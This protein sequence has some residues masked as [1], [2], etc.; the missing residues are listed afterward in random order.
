MTSAGFVASSNVSEKQ[1]EPKRVFSLFKRKF[2]FQKSVCF[3]LLHLQNLR[4]QPTLNFSQLV[5]NVGFFISNIVVIVVVV[6]AAVGAVD[7]VVVSLVI[8]VVVAVV[9]VVI[10][11]TYVDVVVLNYCGEPR[12]CIYCQ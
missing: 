7:V 11:I 12:C 10:I 3:S 4:Q 1:P 8:V 2:V 6:V 5:F 9:I